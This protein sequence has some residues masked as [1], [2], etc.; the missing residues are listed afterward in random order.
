MVPNKYQSQ[1]IK[2]P[3]MTAVPK[4]CLFM[5]VCWWFKIVASFRLRAD[6]KRW[7][8]HLKVLEKPSR[9]N[10]GK[11]KIYQGLLSSTLY[12]GTDLC[13]RMRA[14]AS[15]LL[16]LDWTPLSWLSPS[17]VFPVELSWMETATVLTTKIPLIMNTANY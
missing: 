15:L 9:Q 1:K 2:V 14:V 3:L 4:D 10:K 12:P 16:P 17:D 11:K 5:C 7:I 6:E 8:S 13:W